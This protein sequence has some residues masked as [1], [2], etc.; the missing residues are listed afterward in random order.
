MHQLIV[1]MISNLRK[2]VEEEVPEKGVF[3][4]VYETIENGAFADC[5]SLSSI[6]LPQSIKEIE[7]DAFQNCNSLKQILIPHGT[8]NHFSRFITLKQYRHRLIELSK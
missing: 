7:P 6:T 5:I 2:K 3:E 4:K 8:T 1:N